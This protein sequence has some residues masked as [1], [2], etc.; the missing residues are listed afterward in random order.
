MRDKGGGWGNRHRRPKPPGNRVHPGGRDAQEP[1][2]AGPGGQGAFQAAALGGGEGVSAVD[3]LF[4]LR[5][6]RAASLSSSSSRPKLYS[7]L[8][9]D[10]CASAS[11]SLWASCR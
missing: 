1:L 4:E 3:D 2:Q 11:H 7:T 10:R 6:S 8:V 9:R 5:E